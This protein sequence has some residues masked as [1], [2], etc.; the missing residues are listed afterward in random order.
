MPK[1]VCVVTGSRAEYGL[2][3]WVLRDLQDATDVTLQL[4]VTGMHL[5]REFGYTA[6]VIVRD[7]FSINKRVEMLVSSDTASGVAKSI[8]LGVAGISDA[9]VD[10]DPDVVL[11]LGDRF[12]ILAAVQA[13]LVHAI[14]VAHI[15]GG[16]VTEGAIDESMRHAITKMSHVHFATN[17][18]SA[19]RIRQMGEDP[20][21]VH[22]VG[23]PGLDHLHRLELLDRHGLEDALG[24]PLGERNLLVTF[25]PVTLSPGASLHQL[26]ELFAALDQLPEEFV[27]WCTLPNADTGGRELGESLTRWASTRASRVRVHASL[28]QLRYLSLLREV[29]AVVGNSSS[30]LYEAPSFGVPTVNIGDRQRGRLAADSVFHVEP[31]REDIG[32]GLGEALQRGKRATQNPY[33]DGHSAGRIVEIIRR[34]PPADHLRIKRFHD[35]AVADA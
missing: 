13:C 17:E 33:G 24:A 12:E 2:L 23:S 7:G 16:D 8:A 11:V 30:G 15:A 27:V 25:H 1:R 14:P 18:R 10:L 32:R 19:S 28:G 26:G 3:Y 9:L 34:L 5:A 29:E 4:V 20:A 35:V 21:R 31:T 6:D 22:V